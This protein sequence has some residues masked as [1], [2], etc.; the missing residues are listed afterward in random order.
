MLTLGF[1]LSSEEHDA[2]TLVRQAV[3]AEEAGF[4]FAGI[5]DHYHPWIDNQGNSPFVWAVLGGIAASTRSLKIGTTV[6]CPII[7]I[8]P[9]IIAQAAATVANMM[10]GR[11]FLGLGSGENLNEHV[12][13]YSWPRAAQ[14]IDMLEEAVEIIRELWTGRNVSHDG[15]YFLV[16]DARIYTLP[17]V[18]PPIYLAAAGPTAARLAGRVGEGL[19]ATSPDAELV[20]VFKS[21]GNQGPRIG[22]FT[23]CVAESEEAGVR[24]ASE[25]WPTSALKGS[26]KQE[27]PLP[28]HFQEA[29]A[30]ATPEQIAEAIVCSPDPQKHIDSITE[31]E[32][33]GFDHVY[34]HQI[35]P[36]K[37]TMLDL[38]KREILPRYQG[39]AET[40]TSR[41]EVAASR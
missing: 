34:V 20:Q 26:F 2:Q 22:H 10:P 38:Y 37:E 27:L 17:D 41:R 13:G 5:S 32:R 24:L 29:S 16:E 25:V 31:F 36:D 11:F 21:E 35:G 4:T 9:A 18:L 30:T 3:A 28:R 7:R 23:V 14:R 1:S 15:D 12:V 19:I 33:A 39:R 40:L 6:T 8:H